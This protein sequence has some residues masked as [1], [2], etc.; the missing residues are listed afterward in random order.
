LFTTLRIEPTSKVEVEYCGCRIL[1]ITRI[2]N[3]AILH[4]P[5]STLYY[6][7]DAFSQEG[8][9]HDEIQITKI[10][11]WFE[12]DDLSFQGSEESVLEDFCEYILHRDP[13]I[14][15]C[16]TNNLQ[17]SNIIQD[18]FRRIKRLG[19][20][21]R[22]QRKLNDSKILNNRDFLIKGRLWIS[23]KSF[24]EKFDLAGLIEKARFAFLP[25]ALAVQY[26]MNRLIESRICYELLQRDFVIQDKVYHHDKYHRYEHIGSIEDTID[27]DKAGM[28]FSPQIGLHKN[29]VVLDY[30]N[31]YPNLIMKHNLSY[32]TVKLLEGKVVRNLSKESALL[33]TLIEGV[34]QRRNFFK[35]LS[36]QF[37][38]GTLEWLWCQ[39]RIENIKEYSCESIWYY[40]FLLE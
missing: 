21:I 29:V 16:I 1:R 22:P 27:R 2:E 38:T 14:P 35:N 11:I 40:W 36:R 30:E 4:P 10:R 32:E 8:N 37:G 20:N 7:V 17:G 26:S 18:L 3:D 25:L 6:E 23:N 12:E 33:P 39:Q 31:E 5:F 28:I 9:L 13:D 24:R 34:L 19:F 15:V